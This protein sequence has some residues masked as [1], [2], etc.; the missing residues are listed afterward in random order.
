MRPPYCTGVEFKKLFRLNCSFS[1]FSRN[2][3]C[4]HLYGSSPPFRLNRTFSSFSRN[5]L[6]FRPLHSLRAADPYACPA[7]TRGS[8]HARST[9]LHVSRPH[10]RFHPTY[11]RSTLLHMPAHTHDSIH[12]PPKKKL[13]K[14]FH[15]IYNCGESSQTTALDCLEIVTGSVAFKA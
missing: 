7:H 2:G 15:S 8:I 3:L 9:P 10:T 4:F 11:A 5:D 6:C 13:D 12:P 14:S 1:P